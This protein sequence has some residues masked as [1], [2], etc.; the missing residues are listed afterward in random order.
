MSKSIRLTASASSKATPK[1]IV[2]SQSNKLTGVSTNSKQKSENLK[3]DANNG[4]K[5]NRDGKSKLKEIDYNVE[6]YP[7][8]SILAD[9]GDED[10]LVDIDE[11]KIIDENE[12]EVSDINGSGK[13]SKD[14]ILKAIDMILES[15][16][17]NDF[18]IEKGGITRKSS[19]SIISKRMSFSKVIVKNQL[20]SVFVNNTTFVDQH[21]ENLIREGELKKLLM[22]HIEF[23][24]NIIIKLI[25]YIAVIDD[26]ISFLHKNENSI[27]SS[28]QEINIII[29]SLENFK[30]YL[31]DNKLFSIITRND[32]HS[33]DIDDSI[34]MKLGFLTNLNKTDFDDLHISLPNLG[35][36]LRLLKETMRF[37]YKTISTNNRFNELLESK[38]A[39]RYNQIKVKW[40]LYCGLN[41]KFI[42]SNCVGL[43]II[44][45][46]NTPVGRGWKLSGKR[47]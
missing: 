12:E 9:E 23:S 16:F 47:I 8:S 3:K 45:G 10:T 29:K 27:S 25:D 1:S 39:E 30:K 41:L 26:K 15:R 11:D 4:V 44:E 6:L 35:N 42:L 24:D 43:G 7:L 18:P 46:F 28:Q 36:Y 37:T 21:I 20:Y 33:Y 31:C 5:K 38:L 14:P 17:D 2:K 13:N 32:L 22:N 19:E 34:L 40:Y